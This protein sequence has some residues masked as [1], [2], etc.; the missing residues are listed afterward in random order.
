MRNPITPSLDHLLVLLAVVEAGGFTAA[1][2]R[3]GRAI[4]AVSYA[5][6]TLD[7][8]LGISL[9]DRG[10]TRKPRL[11]QQGEAIVSEARAVAQSVEALRARVTGLLANL[12]PEV[13]LVVDSLFPG[14]RLVAL[15]RDFHAEFPTVPVRLLV[16]TLGGV[17][18]VIRSGAA[19]I[20][21]GSRLHMDAQGFRRF[22]IAGV[23]MIPVAAP[24]HPL[25]VADEAATP[26]SRNFVQLVLS[27]QPAG[28]GQ[29]FGVV[30]L[31]TWRV[32]DITAKHKLLR[33]GIGWGGMPEPMVRADIRSGRLIRLSLRDWRGGEYL[34]QVVHKT[35]TPPGPAGQW[36]IERLLTLSG[37][38]DADI[39][40]EAARPAKG[41]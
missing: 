15:L 16:E 26:S 7:Q 38:P 1:A 37:E 11:T 33:G 14:G 35:D 39:L 4:S 13:S 27:D 20:G 40:D 12:E 31:D 2:K 29:E 41:K 21:V 34:M 25:V 30:S 9:F 18:R 28:E 6:D 23:Q 19:S 10:T 17:E 22:E 24:S 36:L 5:I 3:L 8:Q 32:G